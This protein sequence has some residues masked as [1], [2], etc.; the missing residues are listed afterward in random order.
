MGKVKINSKELGSSLFDFAVLSKNEFLENFEK[1]NTLNM[2][3][4]VK[5]EEINQAELLIAYLWLVFHFLN[6]AGQNKYEK[7]I[8]FFHSR[9]V[10]HLGL[11]KSITE[12]AI[13]HLSK[14]YNEY[15][16]DFQQEN[17][18]G[19]FQKIGMTTSTNILGRPTIDFVFHTN[20]GLS[21]QHSAISLGKLL[22]EFEL[23]D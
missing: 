16:N 20:L 12:Q 8:Y 9:Y 11:S 13:I 10:D 7:S 18:I 19:N 23:T 14:R 21:L 4:K 17:S 2:E 22:K 15:K 5:K 1:Q 3:A 6:I